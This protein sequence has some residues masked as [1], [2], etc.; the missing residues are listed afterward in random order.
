MRSI[1]S[2]VARWATEDC[3]TSDEDVNSAGEIE[4]EGKDVGIKS[5]A[6]RKDEVTMEEYG[7]RREGG[8][9]RPLR[10]AIVEEQESNKMESEIGRK[11]EESSTQKTR[12]RRISRQC[13]M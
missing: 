6:K 10:S 5:K 11:L 1:R 7:E 12:C 8:L 9:V 3:D 4:L 2:G 13:A